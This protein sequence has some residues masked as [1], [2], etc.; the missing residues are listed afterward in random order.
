MEL[1][2]SWL[3]P[4][5]RRVARRV[6]AVPPHFNRRHTPF[7][8][9]TVLESVASSFLTSPDSSIWRS[10]LSTVSA[11]MPNSCLSWFTVFG[12]TRASLIVS[13]R[14]SL[15]ALFFSSF[16]DWQ[17]SCASSRLRNRTSHL[18]RVMASG[19]SL[20]SS[21]S[22]AHK[23]SC[24]ASPRHVSRGYAARHRVR[25]LSLEHDPLPCPFGDTGLTEVVEVAGVVRVVLSRLLDMVEHRQRAAR[26][27]ADLGDREQCRTHGVEV[28][29]VPGELRGQQGQVKRVDERHLDL[30][31]VDHPLEPLP[32][33]LVA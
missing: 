28:A 26:P 22:T 12:V 24:P 2:A 19:S 11:P 3:E 16:T 30:L 20:P 23:P 9:L 27:G 15:S 14:F 13:R 17:A 7:C 21:I 4:P 8:A 31:L 5:G 32:L 18:S 33:S 29:R 1:G 25:H 6:R 10:S